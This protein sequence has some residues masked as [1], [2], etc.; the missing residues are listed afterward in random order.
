M[1]AYID[2]WQNSCICSLAYKMKAFIVEK[3]KKKSVKLTSYFEEDIKLKI[4]YLEE[5]AKIS[6]FIKVKDATAVMP[7][8]PLSTPHELCHLNQVI[9]SIIMFMMG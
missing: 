8:M 4:L 9:T 5:I 1:N 3:A 2:S 6:T 7:K